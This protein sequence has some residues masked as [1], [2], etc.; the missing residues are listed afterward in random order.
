MSNPSP[1]SGKKVQTFPI[2]VTKEDHT[3]QYGNN[4]ESF[5]PASATVISTPSDSLGD[6]LSE[7]RNKKTNDYNAQHNN[8]SEKMREQW[9]MAKMQ[10]MQEEIDGLREELKAREDFSYLDREITRLT[11]ENIQ[12]RLERTHVPPPTITELASIEV[13]NPYLN[14]EYETL[15]DKQAR[16]DKQAKSEST[17]GSGTDFTFQ[18]PNGSGVSLLSISSDIK[19]ISSLRGSRMGL[20][21]A[22]QFQGSEDD[23][24][25]KHLVLELNPR[26]LLGQPAGLVAHILFMCVRY[27]D[28]AEERQR[29][30]AVCKTL[31]LSVKSVLLK[32]SNDVDRVVFWLST[33]S[34]FLSDLK[35]YSGEVRYGQQD[36][37]K[38]LKHFDLTEFRGQVTQLCIA[39][40]RRMIDIVQKDLS[41][42]GF[43]GILEHQALDLGGEHEDGNDLDGFT[44][45][46][47]DP[48]FISRDYI[49][50]NTALSDI[51][52]NE[53]GNNVNITDGKYAN[54]TSDNALSTTS[55]F[56][57]VSVD[58]TSAW[59]EN[60][61][62]ERN[63]KKIPVDELIQ[64]LQ[65][66]VDTMNGYY[67]APDMIA[68]ILGALMDY[69][70]SIC[71]N[72]MLQ[73]P[74]LC[75]DLRGLQISYNLQAL[76]TWWRDQPGTNKGQFIALTQ[77]ARLLNMPKTTRKEIEVVCE[78]SCA[79][80]VSRLQRLLHMYRSP[81]GQAISS[82]ILQQGLEQRWLMEQRK[83]EE[84]PPLLVDRKP[85][86]LSIPYDPKDVKLEDL[87]VPSFLH[88]NFLVKI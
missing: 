52:I 13:K 51:H 40:Q 79:L 37:G 2:N 5:V 19:S 81:D 39:I 69:V 27:L 8:R 14:V 33:C 47:D 59:S 34:R 26:L 75:T 15:R 88:V 30:K 76:N 25:T 45:N 64:Y 3:S 61:R 70:A 38:P 29:M 9:L 80:N 53:K 10:T 85:P 28:H 17:A 48:N 63:P 74:S 11:K 58:A 87:A 72:E 24:I 66:L 4:T 18:T 83:L 71:M 21:G 86:A 1:L 55:T 12:L 23:L 50:M 49:S 42:L 22:F 44:N 60:D 57:T 84:P 20:L 7:T 54:H 65:W 82:H 62:R 32:Y 56:K 35:Q 78:Q 46:L 68:Q 67:L 73:K 77:A 41:V 6:P 16:S 36:S 43:G 31:L